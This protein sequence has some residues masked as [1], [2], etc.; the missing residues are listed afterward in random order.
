MLQRRERHTG[1]NLKKGKEMVCRSRIDCLIFIWQL[2]SH[3]FE[4]AARW[5]KE[6]FTGPSER[7]RKMSV[8][9]MVRYSHAHE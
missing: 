4:E 6:V 9:S 2:T 7:E 3:F 1:T 5:M 8:G